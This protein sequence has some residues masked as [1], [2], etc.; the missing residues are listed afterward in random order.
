MPVGRP[1]PP[2]EGEGLFPCFGG[3]STVYGHCGVGAD[4]NPLQPPE[5]GGSRQG[6]R[7]GP[8]RSVHAPLW[9]LEA[10]RAASCWP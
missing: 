6:L 9:V 2:R 4:P 5:E 1:R 7:H 10:V 3:Y 8:N